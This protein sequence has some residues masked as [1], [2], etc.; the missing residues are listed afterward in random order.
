MKIMKNLRGIILGLGFSILMA[1]SAFAADDAGTI[2]KN[3]KALGSS[4]SIDSSSNLTIGS[5]NI[6]VVTATKP[7]NEATEP[8]KINGTTYYLTSDQVNAVSDAAN[9][10]I[11]SIESAASDI[12]SAGVSSKI[13]QISQSYKLEANT[14]GAASAMNGFKDPLELFVGGL[15]ILIL[16]GLTAVSAIDL[17]YLSIPPLQSFLDSVGDNGGGQGASSST[18]KDGQTKFRFIS[19]EA[20]FAKKKS[21]NGESYSPAIVIYLKNRIVYI[22]ASAVSVYLLVS[23]QSAVLIVLALK[24]ISGVLDMMSGAAS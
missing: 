21:V 23:G 14:D 7:T 5:H 17:A 24:L 15:V 13:N 10:T 18:T 9:D 20:I 19:D 1:S 22:I 4:V 12:S 11:K 6:G 16:L 8:I 2:E 3:L